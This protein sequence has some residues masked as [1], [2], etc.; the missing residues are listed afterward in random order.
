MTHTKEN[1]QLLKPEEAARRA[2]KVA[3]E[4]RK[5]GVDAVLVNDNANLFYLTGRVFCGYILLLADSSMRYFVKRPIHLDGEGITF[6]RKP[7][8]IASAVN[9]ILSEESVGGYMG[10]DTSWSTCERLRRVFGSR[11]TV[12]ASAILRQARAVKTDE[13]IAKMT[14]SGEMQTQVYKH[15]PGLFTEGM[16]DIELQIEIERAL[17]MKGCLGIFRTSGDEL[18]LFMGNVL[19]GENADSPSPYDFAM[20]GRGADPSLPVGADGTLIRVS[21]PVMVDMN[22]NF[23]GYM[24]DMTRCFIVGKVPEEAGRAHRLSVEICAAIAREAVAGKPCKELYEL[25]L[26]MAEE[27]GLA[28]C[29][30]GHRQHAGF[31][32]HGV[33]ITV[34][35]PPVLAPRS[36]DILQAGHTIAVEP[37]FVIPGLGAVGIENTYVVQSEGPAR[38]LTLCPEEIMP[39]L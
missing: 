27:A 18:E 37:K 35:E 10:D 20:G 29:F 5:S 24:T 4:M 23:N 1:L 16:T 22:G 28:D 14:L 12:N 31:V 11:P 7:E 6:I 2:A 39:L 15:V 21:Q 25:A 17:R 8:D 30:M 9:E 38:C 34:N 36:K 13:E 32:G 33:G 26:Q 19:T 3:E